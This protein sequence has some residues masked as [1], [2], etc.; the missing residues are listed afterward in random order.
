[1]R[2]PSARIA[3][4]SGRMNIQSPHPR[5]CG[6]GLLKFGTQLLLRERNDIVNGDFRSPPHECCN[7]TDR[8]KTHDAKHSGKASAKSTPDSSPGPRRRGSKNTAIANIAEGGTANVGRMRHQQL[9]TKQFPKSVDQRG[10]P[11]G[12]LCTIC[13]SPDVLGINMALLAREPLRSLEERTGH[14]KS[15]LQRHQTHIPPILRAAASS[16]KAGDGAAVASAF[17]DLLQAVR[18]VRIQ[19]YN[20]GDMRTFIAAVAREQALI[21][22]QTKIGDTEKPTKVP[23]IETSEYKALRQLILKITEQHPQVR[24]E[25]AA[26]LKEFENEHP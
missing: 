22:I 1:M 18:S 21:A 17:Y 8:R 2:L 15:A 10:R 16:Q 12:C 24:I 9:G 23:F 7:K 6:G 26:A 14:S 5:Q 19:A 13:R 4:L 11:Q 20:D 25:L 3:P